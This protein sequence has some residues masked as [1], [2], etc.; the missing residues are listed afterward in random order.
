MKQVI[1]S[2]IKKYGSLVD[3]K[4]VSLKD[5]F[6]I[7]VEATIMEGIKVPYALRR[8]DPIELKRLPMKVKKVKRGITVES[9]KDVVGK[10]ELRPIIMGVKRDGDMM[11]GTDCHVL[12]A[13]KG[14]MDMVDDGMVLNLQEYIKTKGLVIR[15]ID[16]RY[17]D[18]KVV[19]PDLPDTGEMDLV[20]LDSVCEAFKLVKVN[21]GIDLCAVRID[22]LWFDPFKLA[23]V[24]GFI[25]KA[26]F[27]KCGYVVRNN[28]VIR[29]SFGDSLALVMGLMLQGEE[30]YNRYEFGKEVSNG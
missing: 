29:F 10:D 13:Y 24:V 20:A 30:H 17:P 2:A 6:P 15:G 14:V 5:E 21:T 22:G 16:G 3:S 27:D 1:E 18:W 28:S 12:V 8:F 19:V 4:S 23:K 25:R 7:D 11:V 9:F 26:G